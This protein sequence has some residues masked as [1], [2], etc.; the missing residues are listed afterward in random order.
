MFLQLGWGDVKESVAWVSVWKQ[1]LVS[2]SSFERRG[3]F[4]KEISKGWG[5]RPKT[6]QQRLW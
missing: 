4:S 2:E 1:N 6:V 5:R 3:C